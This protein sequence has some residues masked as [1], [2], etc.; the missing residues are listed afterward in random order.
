MNAQGEKLEMD[1][2]LDMPGRL[3][4][5]LSGKAEGMG[6]DNALDIACNKISALYER[7]E[8]KDFVDAYF[9]FHNLFPFEEL[10]VKTQKKYTGLDLYGLAL[11]FFR[12]KEIEKLPHMI[13]PLELGQLKQFFLE[14]AMELSK[15]FESH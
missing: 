4:P 15:G 9:L 10:W 7:S 11:A 12:V 2:A 8:S 1:F 5:I 6:L 14:K 13:K 3:Q